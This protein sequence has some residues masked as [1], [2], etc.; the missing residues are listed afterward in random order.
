VALSGTALYA[1]A[2]PAYYDAESFI[3]YSA[4]VFLTVHGLATGTALIVLWRNPPVARGSLF[5]LFAG[6]GAVA[7]GLGDLFEDA[8]GIEDAAWIWFGGGVVLLLSLLIAGIAVLTVGSPQ[9]WSGLFL[10]VAAPGAMYGFGLVM[11]GV[12]WVLFALWI[13]YQHRAFVVAMSI[14]A[15]TALGTAI[16]LYGDDVVRDLSAADTHNPQGERTFQAG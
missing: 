4:V 9:R 12:A 10:V 8:F 16:Y 3:D 5:V 11:M 1:F 7:Q 13:V 14:F 15:V 6:I 2:D